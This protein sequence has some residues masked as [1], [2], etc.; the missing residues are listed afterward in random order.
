MVIYEVNWS[1][2]KRGRDTNNEKTSNPS[3]VAAT[4][5][6][7]VGA[8]ARSIVRATNYVLRCPVAK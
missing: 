5:S 3:V 7:A 6:L 1:G 8:K 4:N 2:V